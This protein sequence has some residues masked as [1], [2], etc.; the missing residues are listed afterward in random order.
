MRIVLRS[1]STQ[2]SLEIRQPVAERTEFKHENGTHR[3]KTGEV[4]GDKSFIAPAIH[5]WGW[6]HE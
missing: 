3:G 2:F 4:A 6:G 5:G 1:R